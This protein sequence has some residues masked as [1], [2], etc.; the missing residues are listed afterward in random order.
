MLWCWPAESL[1]FTD[2][3]TSAGRQAMTMPL[4]REPNSRV[5]KKNMI[6]F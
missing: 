6:R 3:P 2:G 1:Y 4:T 5:M